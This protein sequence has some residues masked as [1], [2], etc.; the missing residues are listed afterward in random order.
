MITNEEYAALVAAAAERDRLVA[1]VN[2]PELVEFPRAVYLEAAHQEVRW[3]TTDRE[4]KT[5]ADWFW[6]VAHLATRA[7][8]HHKEAERIRS[9]WGVDEPNKAHSATIA[10]H[11]EKAVHHCI[12][13]A[14][15]LSHWH[16][17]MLGKKTSMQ[18][19]HAP[20]IAI[21]K[22]AGHG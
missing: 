11:R 9:R 19:G 3:G 10:H 6:L 22:E 4:G 7:L 16:A 12:T 8:D 14:A 13:A 1:I 2:T 15:A 5:P 20:S 21:A 17:S 18:P